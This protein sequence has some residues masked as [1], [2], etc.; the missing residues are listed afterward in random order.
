MNNTPD[1]FI[2]SENSTHHWP[3]FNIT[4]HNVLDL[5]CGRWHTTDFDELSPIFFAKKANLVVGVDCSQDEINFFNENTKEDSKF[6][7][8]HQCIN[9]SNQV[10]EMITKYNITALKCDIEGAEEHL[11][12]LT[13]DDLKSIDELAIEYHSEKLKQEFINKVVEWGFEIKITA[14]FMNTPDYMGVLFCNKINVANVLNLN[15]KLAVCYT[16]CG[17]TYRE[18]ALHKLNHLHFDHPNIYYFVLTDNKEYFKDVKR[19]NFVVN[20]LK[21]FYE[22][23]P[24][25][26][27][28]EPFLEST[29]I[30]DYADKFI[31]QNYKFP[32]STNRFH[33]MQAEKFGI[34]NI[35]MLGTDTDLNL[36]IVNDFLEPKNTLY[37]AVSRWYKNISEE[38]MLHVVNI[39]REKYNLPVEDNVMVFDAAAKFFIFDNVDIMKE[40]FKIWNDVMFILY[41]ED[42]I[43]DFGGWYAVND[44][45]ILAPI[46]N[47]LKIEGPRNDNY[48][49]LFDVQHNPAK[50]RFWLYTK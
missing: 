49:A 32:F 35:A 50:E 24:E 8:I 36:S 31:K 18:T 13:K 43:K 12:N 7:F 25:L 47:A 37:N 19:S 4:N 46:Y 26:E 14:Q 9:N 38:S 41:R 20:E 39:L 5:G 27:L 48:V 45:Y 3:H 17:P 33:F 42:K 21:D 16:C 23:Y 30:D 6:V 11:L 40:F 22:E 29:S 28:Y 2:E 44:E 34:C 10:K 15:E 1:Y